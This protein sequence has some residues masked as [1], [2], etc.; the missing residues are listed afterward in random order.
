MIGKLVGLI[1]FLAVT[2]VVAA[3]IAVEIVQQL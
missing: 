2:W 1:V 3:L